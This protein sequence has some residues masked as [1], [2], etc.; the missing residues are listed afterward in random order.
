MR[1]YIDY[2]P[3]NK[4][5]HKYKYLLQQIDDLMDQLKGVCMF[6][7]IDL[8][9]GCHHIRVKSSDTPKT[10]FRIWYGHYEFQVMPFRVTNAP[11]IFMDY[12]NPIFQPY[13][14]GS[15]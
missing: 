7:K 12:M 3:L 10:T 5:Y 2:R 4:G 11:A 9:L 1:L 15:W 14:T 8:R 6:S 13:M